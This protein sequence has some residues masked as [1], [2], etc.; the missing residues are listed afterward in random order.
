M[1][2]LENWLNWLSQVVEPV[3]STGS[4]SLFWKKFYSLFS[5]RLHDFSVTISRCYDDVYFK[6]FFPRTARLCSSLLI[7]CFPLTYDLNG[8]KS[9]INRHVVGSF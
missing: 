2:T 5:N 7:A 8:F 1:K 6:S 9:K 4:T 3:A